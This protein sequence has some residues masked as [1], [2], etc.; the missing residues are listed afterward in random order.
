MLSQLRTRGT[1]KHQAPDLNLCS[2]Q[3]EEQRTDAC[4]PYQPE[5]HSVDGI[6]LR[7]TPMAQRDAV[8]PKATQG[9]CPCQWGWNEIFKVPSKLNHSMILWQNTKPSALVMFSGQ[10]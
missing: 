9:R 3:L 2:G 8:H 6:F 10:N 4:S 5:G 1:I 7:D